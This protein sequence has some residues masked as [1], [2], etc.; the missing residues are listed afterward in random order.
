M[1]TATGHQQQRFIYSELPFEAR[2]RVDSMAY[3]LSVAP[4]EANVAG[5]LAFLEMGS[6]MVLAA[7]GIPD[8]AL[9]A[10][11]LSTMIADKVNRLCTCSRRRRR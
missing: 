1:K 9:L 11:D 6:S 10:E 8:A 5:N 3:V 2:A 4:L 7:L